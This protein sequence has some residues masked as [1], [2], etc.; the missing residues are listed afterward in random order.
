VIGARRGSIGRPS[1]EWGGGRY[2]AI[3]QDGG[4]TTH[5]DS[6]FDDETLDLQRRIDQTVIPYGNRAQQRLLQDRIATKS[7]AKD[8]GAVAEASYLIGRGKVTTGEGDLVDDLGSGRV[9]LDTI[10][11]DQLPEALSDLSG[12]EQDAYV[13]RKQA[14]RRELS[15]Q[16]R[17]LVAKRDT[18]VAEAKKD[19]PASMPAFDT[20]VSRLLSEQ[21]K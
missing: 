11:Q 16:M 6:P 4:Q 7:C 8:H 5:Y 3:A 21:L 18:F 2:I 15:A 17:E 13:I 19:T 1:Q 10:P 12:E 14:E 9:Q 20:E